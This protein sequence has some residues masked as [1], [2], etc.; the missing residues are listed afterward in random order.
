M[1]LSER[2]QELYFEHRKASLIVLSVVV[3][4]GLIWFIKFYG[5][6]NKDVSYQGERIVIDF[7]AHHIVAQAAFETRESFLI[8]NG[9]QTKHGYYYFYAI[10]MDRVRELKKQYGDF[11][12]CDNPGAPTAKASV[13]MLVLFPENPQVDAKVR[14]MLRLRLNSPVIE[15]KAAELYILEHTYNKKV[16]ST[17]DPAMPE[18]YFLVNDAYVINERYR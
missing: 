8:N 5:R 1:N 14:E 17:F 3:V 9:F 16:F 2:L 11:M 13:I 4:A 6:V 15:L 18:T 7:G 10:H 12:R